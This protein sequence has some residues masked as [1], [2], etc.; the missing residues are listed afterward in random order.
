MLSKNRKLTIWS[1][2]IE[3]LLV[4]GKLAELLY[5]MSKENV[6]IA[7]LTEARCRDTGVYNNGDYIILQSGNTVDRYAGVVFVVHKSLEWCIQ[8]F[9]PRSPRL[10]TLTLKTTG[11]AITL[12]LVYLPYENVTA[13]NMD[14]RVTTFEEYSA[15]LVEGRRKGPVVALGDHNTSVRYRIEGEQ[16]LGRFL[17]GPRR[18]TVYADADAA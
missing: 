17:Y 18:D 11:G 14:L 3:S 13:E 15:A 6:L 1:Y 10:A 2:N 8:S 4:T 12:V 7:G 16:W 5:M 9:T